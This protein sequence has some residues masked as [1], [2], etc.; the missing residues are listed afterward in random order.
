MISRISFITLLLYYVQLGGTYGQSFV[1]PFFLL[2]LL[3]FVSMIEK[4]GEE[5]QRKWFY[6]IQIIYWWNE[7]SSGNHFNLASLHHHRTLKHNNR[8]KVYWKFYQGLNSQQL[9]AISILFWAWYD[10]EN[11]IKYTCT[12]SGMDTRYETMN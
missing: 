6:S 9:L 1:E 11:Y 10:N 3:T 2:L 12:W 5:I 4:F 8:F 7:R